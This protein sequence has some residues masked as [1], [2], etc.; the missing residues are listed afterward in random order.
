[1]TQDAA[2]PSAERS[3]PDE[4]HDGAGAAP[5]AD[6]AP[7][8]QGK[9][10][11]V[12]LLVAAAVGIVVSL[13]TW[14][15]LELIHQLHVEVF[16][17]LP[18]AVGY[19]NGAPLWWSLP[20]C[21]IAGL[22]AAVAIMRLPGSGGHVPAM[23]LSAGAAQPVELPG[24]VLAAVASIGLGLVLGPEAPLIALGS[25]LG[26][27]AVR[28]VREDAPKPLIAV[29]AAAGS[30]AAISFLFVAPAIAAVLLIE[31]SGIGGKQLPLV[32]IPGLLAAGIGSLIS[33]GMG[34][35]TGL[36]T[37][38]YAIGPLPLPPLDRPTFVEFAWTIPL[39]IG[40]TLVCLAVVL[41]GRRVQP[42]VMR[43]PYVLLP[44]AGLLVAG[45]AIG[46]AELTDKG[47]DQVLFS[48]EDAIG[49][50]TANAKTWSVGALV[51]VIAF[52]GA[53]WGIS[54]G[55][56]RGG[57]VFPA[58]FLGT[59]AGVLAS[60]LP[61]MPMTPAVAVA[62]GASVVAVLRL[63]LSAV[64]L[65]T[66]LT[67]KGGLADTPLIIVGVVA[68]YVVA[69]ALSPRLEAAAPAPAERPAAAVDHSAD[70]SIPD[71]APAGA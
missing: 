41:V 61:G 5:S 11:L 33:I 34:S 64:I 17:K 23:G 62:M 12:V 53:A 13:A 47:V 24:I 60:H 55:S 25:G 29:M 30:F 49:P 35:F 28:L 43:A 52:K 1:M 2:L 56:F 51:A 66:L 71:A 3:S 65:A 59:A 15:F 6:A 20:V 48:G 38:A 27:L 67:T 19:G 40:I 36:S 4:P 16:D 26:I 9:A 44:A 8:L 7:T 42:V 70:A 39:A 45:L 54:L 37:S 10:A 21:A 31:A 32:I 57:P 46:F 58:M 69:T 14:C 68:A 18:A 22:I 63:P 50:L